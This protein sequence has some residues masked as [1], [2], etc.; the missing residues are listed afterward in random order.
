MVAN[1]R[2]IK[3]NEYIKTNCT[4]NSLI[5][6]SNSISYIPIYHVLHS[7]CPVEISTNQTILI[8]CHIASP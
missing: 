6:M 5:K 1:K 7:G 8:F 3:E 4:L 2:M